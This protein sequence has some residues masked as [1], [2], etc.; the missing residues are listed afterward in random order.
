MEAL[1]P[2]LK[3]AGGKRWLV[4]FM[5]EHLYKDRSVKLVEPFCGALGMTLGL[6]PQKAVLNDANPHLI[7]FH[8]HVAVGL[9][10]PEHMHCNDSEFYYKQRSLFNACIP[11]VQNTRLAAQLFYY[12]NRTGFN[13][14]CRF[15]QK[16]K[17]NVPFGKYKTINYASDFYSYQ[18]VMAQWEFYAGDFEPVASLVDENTFTYC[19]P[20]YD[21]GFT[22]YSAGDFSWD[23]QVRLATWVS[24]LPGRVV[25]SNKATDRIVE[26]YQ[27]LEFDVYLIEA[28]R[29]VAAN[30]NRDKVF[31][32]IATN[33]LC[34]ALP[35]TKTTLLT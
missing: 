26:L 34:P 28:P 25:L 16:G 9:D 4:P 31:E 24:K 7:N 32:I 23:D 12:L 22:A 6:M 18:P 30:G 3:W 10:F 8:S 15:N 35:L 14:L 1:T 11:D 13:G 2:P 19:D 29:R 20:P 33:K 5:K 27:G 21:D 17:F